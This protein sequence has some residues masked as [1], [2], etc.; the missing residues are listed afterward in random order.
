M[1]FGFLM[2][3][4]A[5]VKFTDV[6]YMNEDHNLQSD[7][8]IAIAFNMEQPYYNEVTCFPPAS[9]YCMHTHYFVCHVC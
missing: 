1:I 7:K 6:Y 4:R 8:T 9:N 5:L 3:S 2:N